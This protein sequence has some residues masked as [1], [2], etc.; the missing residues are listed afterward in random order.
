MLSS[1]EALSAVPL[2]WLSAVKAMRPILASCSTRAVS[3]SV[4]LVP[5]CT[6]RVAER[7]SCVAPA[8][9]AAAPTMAPRASL[10]VRGA[11]GMQGLAEHFGDDEPVHRSHDGHVGAAQRV[12]VVHYGADRHQGLAVLL[13]LKDR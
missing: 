2:S 5:R 1:C 11:C 9:A 8:C 3:L 4:A 12:V 13:V 7:A 10:L 6:S